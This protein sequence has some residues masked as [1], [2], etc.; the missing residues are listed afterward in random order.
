[1]AE[2]LSGVTAVA[3]PL[4]VGEE[5]IPELDQALVILGQEGIPMVNMTATLEALKGKHIG[6]FAVNPVNAH[7]DSRL[8]RLYARDIAD[9]ILARKYTPAGAVRSNPGDAPIPL[10]AG[11]AVQPGGTTLLYNSKP[12]PRKDKPGNGLDPSGQLAP[13]IL[14]GSPYA[15]FPTPG[16]RGRVRLK[17]LSGQAVKVTESLR[18]P[19]GAEALGRSITLNPGESITV[20]DT[21]EMEAL[22]VSSAQDTGCGLKDVL[23]APEF[24]I[25]IVREG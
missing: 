21:S 4:P 12:A 20:D 10:D 9:A 16:E 25:E 11:R 3:A 19:S 23:A 13:C 6:D 17:L 22:M 24:R 8:V 14:I 5:E 18:D 15:L 2:A 7:P 1:M